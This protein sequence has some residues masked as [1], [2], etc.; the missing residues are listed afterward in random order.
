[1][2][3]EGLV[4]KLTLTNPDEIRRE[5]QEDYPPLLRDAG[6]GGTATVWAYVDETG[7]IT[8]L[9][10]DQSSGYEALDQAAMRVAARLRFEPATEA[11]RV[12]TTW[13]ACRFRFIRSDE[14]LEQPCTVYV[15]RSRGRATG[16][17]TATFT[18][19]TTCTLAVDVRVNP[20][21][22]VPVHLPVRVHG[23]SRFLCYR[24]RGARNLTTV[25]RGAGLVRRAARP[26]AGTARGA[27][28]RAIATSG[29]LC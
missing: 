2:P 21:V 25:L 7:R 6:I 1:L 18:S 4:R 11:G 28:G 20:P 17:R 29:V 5:L 9:Q 15:K 8:K 24:G 16:R 22:S 10:L 3:T 12:I 27:R 13:T 23:H 19:R 14:R 26:R